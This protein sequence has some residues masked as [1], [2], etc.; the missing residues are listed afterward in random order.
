MTL[1]RS[2]FLVVVGA[3]LRYAL[4]WHTTGVDLQVLGLILM[5][6]GIVTSMICL[7]R[8]FLPA[9]ARATAR[10]RGAGRTPIGPGPGPIG[11]RIERTA[12]F[13][14]YRYGPPQPG[15]NRIQRDA[16][17]LDAGHTGPGHTESDR[18]DAGYADAVD[19]GPGSGGGY[20]PPCPPRFT[21]SPSS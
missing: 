4:T 20:P 7:L 11:R 9:P 2:V 13:G 14:T 3:I 1:G 5:I 17:Y 10:T 12:A 21:E 19:D 8:A 18:T 15:S 6:T 16:G